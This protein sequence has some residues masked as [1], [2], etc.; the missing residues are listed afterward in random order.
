M[1]PTIFGAL[2]LALVPAFV[3][4]GWLLDVPCPG[5][6]ELSRLLRRDAVGFG[7]QE[8]LNRPPT[9]D[10]SSDK[11]LLQCKHDS[12][13]VGVCILTTCWSEGAN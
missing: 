6:G 3:M 13:G 5:G 4:G 1:R 9:T 2:P 11:R 12:R 7:A 10:L 8:A